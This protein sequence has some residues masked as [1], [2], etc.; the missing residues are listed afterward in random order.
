[1]WLVSKINL[2][3]ISTLNPR[4]NAKKPSSPNRLPSGAVALELILILSPASVPL[5]SVPS[6]TKNVSPSSK[7]NWPSNIKL[8]VRL[9]APLSSVIPQLPFTFPNGV[10]AR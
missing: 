5:A 6:K 3:P 2:S 10:S 8:S 1:M 9:P 7:G 4:G